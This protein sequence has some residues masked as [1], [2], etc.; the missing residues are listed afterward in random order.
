MARMRAVATAAAVLHIRAVLS[1]STAPH[2]APPYVEHAG[3]FCRGNQAHTFAQTTEALDACT[4][5]CLA[6]T[7]SCFDIKPGICRLTNWST[8]VH[9]SAE[10]TVAYVDGRKPHS[11]PS[12]SP[13]HGG[14]PIGKSGE[15]R[16][17]CTGEHAT[18]PFCDA[19]LPVAE[20]VAK[21]IALL[22]PEEKGSL[23]AA[24]TTD[25]TNAIDRLGVPLF[26]WGQN[27]A[28]GYLQTGLPPTGGSI[29]T[30]PRA[31][32]MAATCAYLDAVAFAN[33]KACA[34]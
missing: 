25:W 34:T 21:L 8:S 16:Y 33:G 19:T 26:C 10:G 24:R 14:A 3:Y 20:R 13:H 5:H 12:P 31:P 11:S 9:K 4:A 22:T 18:Q 28:Q 23:M 32:G 2:T 7:C 27:S 15:A 6:T 1:S 17:G 29:T 30:F